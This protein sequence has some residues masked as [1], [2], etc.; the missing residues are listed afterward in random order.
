METHGLH[1]YEALLV[2]D[3]AFDQTKCPVYSINIVNLEIFAT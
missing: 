3:Q 1:I 2:F